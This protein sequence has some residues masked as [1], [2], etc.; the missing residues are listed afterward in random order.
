MQNRYLFLLLSF[1]VVDSIFSTNISSSGFVGQTPEQR[2]AARKQQSVNNTVQ[3]NTSQLPMIK[4]QGRYAAIPQN[5]V[6]TPKLG[7][8]AVAAA[9]KPAKKKRW[10]QFWKK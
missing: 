9:T 7:G 10:Y 8:G 1:F 3:K 6:T 4:T 2:F 5:P